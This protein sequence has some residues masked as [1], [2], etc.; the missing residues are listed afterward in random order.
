[1]P[2]SIP[3]KVQGALREPPVDVS[4]LQ[5]RFWTYLSRFSSN[6]VWLSYARIPRDASGRLTLM[7]EHWGEGMTVFGN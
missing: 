5:K 6:A 1:M 4:D 7:P 2:E 3:S